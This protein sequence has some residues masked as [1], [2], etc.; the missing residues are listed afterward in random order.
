MSNDYETYML[1]AIA[2]AQKAGQMNE[3]PIGA[4]IVSGDDL[5]IKNLEDKGGEV[6]EIL[7]YCLIALASA[8]A[9]A[10]LKHHFI[11]KDSTLKRMTGRI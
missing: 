10:A 2:E 7:A 11:D 3:V 9:L 8:H 5:G 4:A 6:H 1:T